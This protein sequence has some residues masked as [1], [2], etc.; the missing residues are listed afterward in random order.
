MAATDFI[1]YLKTLT[2]SLYQSVHIN[3]YLY[4]QVFMYDVVVEVVEPSEALHIHQGKGT[5]H[6]CVPY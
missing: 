2:R 4:V 1:I 5:D 6:R 3:V